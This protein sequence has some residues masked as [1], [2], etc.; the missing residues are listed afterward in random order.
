MSY[1]LTVPEMLEAMQDIAP[2]RAA[3]F[4]KSYCD[5]GDA[6]AR[7]IAQSLNIET[8]GQCIFDL[9][10][11]QAQFSP[12]HDGQALPDAIAGY[13]SPKQWGE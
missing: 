9:G 3:E 1:A 10:D 11:A 8:H 6:M 2:D 5:L 4:R 7:Q 13:D 12:A